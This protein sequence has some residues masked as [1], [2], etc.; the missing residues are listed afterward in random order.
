M[1]RSSRQKISKA[2]EFLNNTIDQLDLIDIYRTLHKKKKKKQNKTHKTKHTFFSITHGT[3]THGTFSRIDY[4][5]GYKTSL[6]KF[7]RIEI[8]S[9]IFSDQKSM[10]IE[11]NH[12]KKNQE[13]NK[14]VET[15][16]HAT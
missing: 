13:W 12:R 3:I 8:I 1:D 15:K 6:N 10:K 5:L 14:Q 2:T 9:G 11:I 4:I 16:Q 7:K